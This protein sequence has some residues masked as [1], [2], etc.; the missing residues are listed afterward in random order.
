MLCS[1]PIYRVRIKLGTEVRLLSKNLQLR[2]LTQHNGG[3]DVENFL[4]VWVQFR[5]KYSNWLK[6]K[7]SVVQLA[8]LSILAELTVECQQSTV[9]FNVHFNY[10]LEFSS[11][12]RILTCCLYI[13][14][15][16]I[17]WAFP[18]TVNVV[19]KWL[20]LL[21]MGNGNRRSFACKWQIDGTVLYCRND[22][23]I[24]RYSNDCMTVNRFMR[25]NAN[26]RIKNII[27]VVQ[28]QNWP[29]TRATELSP[30]FTTRDDVIG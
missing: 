7:I 30:L 18:C 21:D 13:H 28:L 29:R 20:H 16:S 17:I 8:A 12:Q 9:Q 19:W 24:K 27:D 14:G 5:S 1:H 15:S 23:W 4:P 3:T 25:S 6:F 26:A 10:S 11:H 2:R 22:L